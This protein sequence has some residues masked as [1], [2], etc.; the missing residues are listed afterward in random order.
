MI[1]MIIAIALFTIPLIMGWLKKRTRKLINSLHNKSNK[2]FLELLF[3]QVWNGHEADRAYAWYRV[4]LHLENYY[5]QGKKRDQLLKQA[6]L[7][8]WRYAKSRCV[9]EIS[10][11][12][13]GKIIEKRITTTKAQEL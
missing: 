11:S 9:K 8:I 10:L 6:N 7:N 12:A 1:L 2:E 4:K 5:P 3:Y 13:S